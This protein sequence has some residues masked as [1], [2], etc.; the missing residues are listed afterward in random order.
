MY[1]REGRFRESSD[2]RYRRFR[3]REERQIEI[4]TLGLVLIVFMIPVL[5][6]SPNAD[7]SDASTPVVLM[8]GGIILLA[9]AFF[10]VQRR[11]YVNPLTW[12]GGAAMLAF[13]F[14]EFQSREQ[15]LGPLLPILLFGG[16]IL[17]SFFTGQF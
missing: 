13:G 7:G 15:P 5:F 16:V 8:L 4:V 11:F 12:L 1:G 3:Q 6:P 14:Y 9:G 17:G 2:A 10:Q